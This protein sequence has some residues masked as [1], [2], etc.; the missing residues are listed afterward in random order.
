MLLEAGADVNLKDSDGNSPIEYAYIGGRCGPEADE[1]RLAVVEGLAGRRRELQKLAETAL[2][3]HVLKELRLPQDRLPDGEASNVYAALVGEKILVK[4]ALKVTRDEGSVYHYPRHSPTNADRLYHAG[5]RDIDRV[6][7][8]GITPLMLVGQRL[9]G[10]VGSVFQRLKYASWLISK[11]ADTHRIVPGSTTTALHQ[12]C[13]NIGREIL[14][15]RYA[16]DLYLFRE[17]EPILDDE[18]HD[19][20]LEIATREDADEYF[21][22]SYQ[23]NGLVII[24]R[25]KRGGPRTF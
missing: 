17:D 10:Y 11:G 13:F 25:R 15:W 12:F 19:F 14:P 5:F 2:P 20:L 21:C 16:T 24:F 8:R 18:C 4:P 7:P 6:D 9:S 1:A 3:Q 23:M 22:S